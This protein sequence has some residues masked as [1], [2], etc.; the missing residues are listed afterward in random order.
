M[1][2][3]SDL[4]DLI[5]PDA[6]AAWRQSQRFARIAVTLFLVELVLFPATVAVS[7][8]LRNWV[9]FDFGVLVAT[10]L[11][12][13]FLTYLVKALRWSKQATLAAGRY[14]APQRAGDDSPVPP[15]LLRGG[16]ESITTFLA[17]LEKIRLGQKPPP[18]SSIAE[19]R[20]RTPA[21]VWNTTV[22]GLVIITIGIILSI[23]SAVEVV[24]A[25]SL[26]ALTV[27]AAVGCYL[28]GAPLALSL[29]RYYRRVSRDPTK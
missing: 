20:D 14:L 8:A 22:V 29:G 2:S 9:V 24:T 21:R 16:S 27:P 26:T 7:E 3:Q 18:A 19:F 4:T 5:G 6:S 23:A 25:P 17:N 10:V 1:S 12:A 28:I 13:G 15:A 11:L